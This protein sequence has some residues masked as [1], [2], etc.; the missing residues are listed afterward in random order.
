MYKYVV[1]DIRVHENFE[2]ISRKTKILFSK[3]SKPYPKNAFSRSYLFSLFF[4][5][6]NISK[7]FSV[8]LKTYQ[9]NIIVPKV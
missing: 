6:I 1:M 7:I 3:F 4:F 8:I 2:F 9:R 5:K